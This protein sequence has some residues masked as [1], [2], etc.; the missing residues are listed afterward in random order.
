MLITGD[1]CRL[2]FR[3]C[4]ECA[5]AGVVVTAAGLP[6]AREPEAVGH[7]VTMVYLFCW[8]PFG[9]AADFMIRF[10]RVALPRTAE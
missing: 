10:L 1:Y 3:V 8:I 5:V 9:F 2:T 6:D 7:A 4:L